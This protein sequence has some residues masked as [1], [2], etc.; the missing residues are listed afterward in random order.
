MM[1]DLAF[2]LKKESEAI[3]KA[4]EKSIEADYVTVDLNKEKPRSTSE[5]GD[6]IANYIISNR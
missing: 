2:G 6:W 5:V 4:V 3:V 1:F